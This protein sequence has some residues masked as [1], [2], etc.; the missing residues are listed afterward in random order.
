MFKLLLIG[1]VI[2][3]ASASPVDVRLIVGGFETSIEEQ[4]WQVSLQV[5]TSHNCGGSIIGKEW[6]LTAAHCTNS[7]GSYYVRV[8]SS[9][10]A[11]GG[12][13]IKVKKVYRHEK[14]NA[15]ITDFDFSLLEL[16][17]PLSFGDAVKPIALPSEDIKIAD[18]VEV[19]VSGWGA[20]QNSSDSNEVLRAVYIP[21]A[22][23]EY[24][25][26][27][28]KY[29]GRPITDRMICAGFVKGDKSPCYGDSGGPLSVESDGDRVVIGVVSWGKDC[30]APNYPG[31]FGRITSVR[32]WIKS[33]SGI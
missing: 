10:Y 6:V 26:E 33:L 30:G 27:Q 22:N 3:L 20:T 25:S 24:C 15:S 17:E 23:Q 28:Y 1:F 5:G 11:S 31:V 32:P 16:A 7:T 8:G 4:P 29:L 9:R 14:Y 19:L 18:G 2:G 13:T 21:I 12:S